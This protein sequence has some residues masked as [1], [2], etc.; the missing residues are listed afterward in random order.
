[1]ATDDH[2]IPPPLHGVMAKRAGSTV[3]EIEVIAWYMPNKASPMSFMPAFLLGGEYARHS[4]DETAFGGSR[5]T[6]YALNI[7]AAGPTTEALEADP[8]W[9]K[10]FWSDLVPFAVG[11]GSH[12]NFMADLDHDRIVASYGPEKY[13]RLSQIKAIYDPDNVFHLNANIRPAVTV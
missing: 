11:V 4:D 10:A 7:A 12:V 5:Q 1:M 9:V 3:A 6:R 8:A 13:G 2:M